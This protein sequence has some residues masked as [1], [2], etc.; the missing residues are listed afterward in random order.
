MGTMAYTL[1]INDK[2]ETAYEDKTL[3]RYLRDD[4]GLVSV[5]DGC[6][7]GMC[8]ACTVLI[9][10]KPARSCIQRLSRL[11]GKSI[12]TLEGLDPQRRNLLAQAYAQAG[13]VQCGFC[14]PGMLMVTQGLLSSSAQVPSDEEIRK[15]LNN[16][17]CRCTGYV[18]IIEA[19]KL[20]FKYR[21]NGV[22]KAEGNVAVGNS[23]VRLDAIRKALGE[24][25]F[26]DDLRLDG[27]VYARAL[28]S[29][30]PRAK[31]LSIDD[32][33]ARGQN[34]FIA[35]FTAS[36]V[37]CNKI[38][39]IVHDWD[40]LIP[41]GSYTRYV[42]DAVALVV[43]DTYE[44]A[45]MLLGLINV[46]YQVETPVTTAEQALA[47]GAPLIHESGNL[48]SLVEIR[49]GDADQAISAS[50]FTVT[51]SFETPVTE[52]AFMEPEC[53]VASVQDDELVLYSASQSVYDDRD[54]LALMLGIPAQK[55]RCRGL[56]I[57]G[58]FG[59]KEDMSVQHHAGLAAWLLRRPVKVRFTRQE[60]LLVHP[61]RHPM[62]MDFTVSCDNDG[63]LTAMKALLVTD[64]GAY[65][66]L[67]MPVLQRACTHAAGPYRLANIEIIGKAVYTN[68][69]P[70]G[71]FRGFG[72]TQSCFAMESCINLLAQKIGMDPFEFRLL[73]AIRPGQSLP[74]GQIA[75]SDTAMVE[76]L[77]ALKPYYKSGYGIACAI[78]N[79]GIGVGL[80]DEGQCNIAVR[81]HRIHIQCSA[82][83]MGQG[84]ATVALQI[85]VQAT[86]LDAGLFIVDAPDTASTPDSGTSTASRQTAISGEA[87][88]RAAAKLKDALSGRSLEDLEGMDFSGRFIVKTDPFGS[89]KEHPS[90][91]L[92]YSYGAQVTSLDEQGRIKSIVAAFDAGQVI[93][94]L[95]FSGQ[96]EGGIVMGMGYALTESFIQ[97]EGYV[98]TRYGT[99]G[100]TRAKDVPEIKVITVQGPGKL[101]TAYGAKGIGE[102]CTIACAPSI[103]HAYWLRDGLLRTSLPIAQNPYRKH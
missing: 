95:A 72:V 86:G 11:E 62:K 70:C 57:G 30:Y 92:S 49:R 88:R 96:V 20:A 6:S 78:K 71:A 91:H 22:E 1:L 74:N 28:R 35:C 63:H 55:I 102:L 60:S 90:S 38:G 44:N 52:H 43:A 98:K 66:S 85:A 83:C 39:R 59:G 34:G 46:V 100:L 9:D 23:P 75:G 50:P 67:G 81:S 14:T 68:N 32:S 87:V 77:M 80:D 89:D 8:G 61:K 13:A 33:K 64:N 93:N 84:F 69:V 27:M 48:L 12:T 94:P 10:G 2:H 47:P 7:E 56:F 79:S 82:A 5:K 21:D 4:L 16:N 41:V 58:G 54:Q 73:N 53:A 19:V 99:L 31:V 37:P 29:P 65:A 40:V 17:I 25:G 24:G 51:Q 103:A 26:C 76:C 101:D 45:T 15:A 42:G 97:D 3:L 36:D 18:K